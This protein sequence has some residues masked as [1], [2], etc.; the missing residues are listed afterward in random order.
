MPGRSNN[1]GYIAI[2]SAIVISALLLVISGIVSFSSYLSR[3]N[4]LDVS[5]KEE[6]RALA[7]ACVEKALLKLALNASYGGNEVLAI[8][9]GR[10]CRI[11]PVESAGG[12]KIVKTT[13]AFGGAVSNLKVVMVLSPPTII[14]WEEV[15]KF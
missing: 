4:V 7:E 15:P 5:S 10:S 9:A 6:S 12:Q 2:T 1:R 14:S 8:T 3:F 11:L 13:A